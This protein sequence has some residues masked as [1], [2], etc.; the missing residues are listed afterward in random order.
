MSLNIRQQKQW[1]LRKGKWLRWVLQH[2]SF[3]SLD[4]PGGNTR[5][6]NQGRAQKTSWFQE[7]KLKFQGNQTDKSSQE[8]IPERRELHRERKRSSVKDPFLQVSAESWSAHEW[9]NLLNPGKELPKSI[10]GNMFGVHTKL[11]KMLVP[12]TQTGKHQ[13]SWSIR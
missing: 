13:D 6:R 7:V 5:R 10:G 12:A 3:L 8:R 9:E 11:G 1:S 4:S 2:N